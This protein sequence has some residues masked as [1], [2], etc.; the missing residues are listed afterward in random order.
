M[1][2]APK[3]LLAA[4]ATMAAGG[5]VAGIGTAL[6]AR[7]LWRKLRE[8]DFSGKVVVI[9]GGSRGLGLAIAHEFA[10]EGT[11]LAICARG[12][13]ELEWAEQELRSRGADVFSWPWVIRKRC[14][15][16]SPPSK[17]DTGLL[18]SS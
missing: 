17:S 5:A 12:A 14:A 10:V 8:T 3:I 13:G 4:T 2:P 9:T 1:R 11:R 6:V 18:M 15:G 7:K 16:S